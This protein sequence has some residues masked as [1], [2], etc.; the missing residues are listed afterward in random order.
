[1]E[2]P[3]PP[4]RNNKKRVSDC[5]EILC[6]SHTCRPLSFFS[7]N[8]FFFFAKISVLSE[9]LGSLGSCYFSF[10]TQTFVTAKLFLS[11]FKKY[12]TNHTK[13]SSSN[14][15]GGGGGGGGGG[16]LVQVIA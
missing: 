11:V 10:A 6:F 7:S 14:I 2:Y 15:G 13:A 9:F 4:P 5:P 1:M 3:P 12:F 16:K 8:S